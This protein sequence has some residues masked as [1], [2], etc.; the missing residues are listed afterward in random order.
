MKLKQ[1]IQ[2]VSSFVIGN[3]MRKT[4]DGVL[5]GL[6]VLLFANSPGYAQN[7]E[8]LSIHN[9]Y[10]CMHDVPPVKWSTTV[11][12]SAQNYA[13][14][15]PSGHSGSQYGENIGWAGYIMSPTAVVSEW[16]SEAPMYN[17]NNPAWSPNYGHF[18]QVVWKG[19]I[20][21]GCGYH[22]GCTTGNLGYPNV[23]IC[24]YNP[25]GNYLTQFAAN[26]LKP[27]RIEAECKNSEYIN[28][29]WRQG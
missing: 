7:A 5:L 13:D 16:Y 9:T 18:T 15:R 19:T 2:N 1:F 17:Y 21:I 29:G 4:I 26:V 6:M 10:R 3:A 27:V 23:W 11:A 8:W 24:Q 28:G 25:P 14:T 12:K 20:E 22:T